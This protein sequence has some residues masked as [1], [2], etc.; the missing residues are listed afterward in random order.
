MCCTLFLGVACYIK[1]SPHQIVQSGTVDHLT[2]ATFR[3]SMFALLRVKLKFPAFELLGSVYK[4]TNMFAF[5]S[6]QI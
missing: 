5:F 6:F 4:S 3:N 2:L 1:I